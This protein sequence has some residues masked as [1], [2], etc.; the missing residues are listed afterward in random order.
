VTSQQE[1]LEDLERMIASRLQERR[2]SG[3][4]RSTEFV[5]SAEQFL[6]EL[7]RLRDS[8]RSEEE[9]RRSEETPRESESEGMSEGLRVLF[10]GPEPEAPR[11]RELDGEPEAAEQIEFPAEPEVAE[12][13]VAPG[14]QVPPEPEV[15]REPAAAPGPA[16]TE[17]GPGEREPQEAGAIGGQSRFFRAFLGSLERPRAPVPT[18]FP[19][20]DAL[21]GGGLHPGLHVISG[22]VDSGGRAFLQNVLWKAVSEERRAAYFTLA[23]GSQRAWEEMIVTLSHLLGDRPLTLEQIR[24]TASAASWKEEIRRLDEMLGRSLIPYVHLVDQVVAGP[25]PITAFLRQLDESLEVAG[26]APPLLLIDGL[27]QLSIFLGARRQ[28]EVGSL[29]L[30]LDTYLRGRRLPG[31]LLS[32]WSPR[33][34]KRWEDQGTDHLGSGLIQFSRRRR[35]APLAQLAEVGVTVVKQPRSPR[36]GKLRFALDRASGLLVEVPVLGD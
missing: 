1:V 5:R 20:L 6:D 15:A 9:A 17:T 18:G 11:E 19:T 8:I 12:P 10:R 27:P 33:G 25:F 24:D 13:Y 36:Q 7:E 28:L 2:G 3:G 34:R 35:R 32:E 14:P 29:V 23:S 4:S 16:V 26:P 31:L 21:L 22:S 30:E